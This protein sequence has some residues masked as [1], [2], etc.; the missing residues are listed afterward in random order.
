MQIFAKLF[1]VRSV[2]TQKYN[3]RY[4]FDEA[5]HWSGRDPGKAGR[6]ESSPASFEPGL[7]SQADRRMFLAGYPK[8]GNPSHSLGQA[9][10]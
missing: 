10:I 7:R 8:V 6:D 2:L 9:E 4:E 3:W 1:A 5:F